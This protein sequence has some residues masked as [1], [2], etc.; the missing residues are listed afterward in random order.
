MQKERK[1]KMT[2]EPIEQLVDEIRGV[3]MLLVLQ[4]LRDGAKQNEI[5]L[6]LGLS[7]ATISRMIPKEAK[8][9]IRGR[10]NG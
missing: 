4:L 1:K 3:K 8:A 5:A 7:E 6:M 2:K 9:S 10:V